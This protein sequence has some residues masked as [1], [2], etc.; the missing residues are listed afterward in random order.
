MFDGV[1]MDVMQV[2]FK[3][4]IITDDVIPK[5]FL[6]E[7]HG[8]GRSQPESLLIC[9]R[10][11]GLQGVHDFTK[12]AFCYLNQ[13]MKMVVQEYISEH[14][15]RVKLLNIPQCFEQQFNQQ[16]VAENR[17]SA[18]NYLCKKYS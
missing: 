10:K 7:F 14:I 11:I 5:A 17:F 13:N 1:V 3:I 18:L 6:P 12:V 9:L 15:E 2:I 4:S 8:I 16:N